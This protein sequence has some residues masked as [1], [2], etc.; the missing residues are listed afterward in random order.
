MAKLL[1][2][3]GWILIAS[4]ALV[5]IFPLVSSIATFSALANALPAG[6]L[7]SLGAQLLSQAKNVDDA[8]AKRSSFYLDS[9]VKAYEEAE[10]LLEDGN[11]DRVK[12]IAAGRALMHA[13]ELGDKITDPSHKQVLEIHRVKYRRLFDD[14]LRDKTAAFFFGAEDPTAPTATAAA[15]STERETRAGRTVTSTVRE[16][17][18]RS[19]R[20]VWEA[21]Q[22]PKEYEDPLGKGFS[23]DE[24]E[25][26]TLLYPGLYEFFEHKRQWHSASGRLHPRDSR[27]AR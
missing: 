2:A 26:L 19:I 7:V 22:W 5:V 20:A 1:K 24:V 3:L 25:R 4:G 27:E 17:S 21:A 10:S 12:W 18:G 16:L 14:A 23:S 6:V 13:K 8:A 15:E 11:N 9:C